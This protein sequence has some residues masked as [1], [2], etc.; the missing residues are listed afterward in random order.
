MD[1]PKTDS[2]SY[3]VTLPGGKLES[4]NSWTE[5]LTELLPPSTTELTTTALNMAQ[6]PVRSAG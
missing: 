4:S 1:P 2:V 3:T 6:V 5:A